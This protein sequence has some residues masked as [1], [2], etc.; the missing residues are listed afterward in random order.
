MKFSHV[1]AAD[2]IQ[3]VQLA[4]YEKTNKMARIL[5]TSPRLTLMLGLVG[6][7]ILAVPGFA[8]AGVDATGGSDFGSGDGDEFEDVWSRLVGWTQG[9]LGR[10][11]ALTLI[12]VGAAMGV[13]RQSLITFVVGIAMGLGLYN[14][15]SII[16]AVMGATLDDAPLIIETSIHHGLSTLSGTAPSIE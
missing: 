6:V 5:G 9:T 12:L 15:P 8:V 13:V 11:I 3:R 14:A 16:D 7:S 2:P 1:T 4:A 10:I